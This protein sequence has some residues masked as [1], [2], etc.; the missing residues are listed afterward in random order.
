M[1]PAGPYLP[2]L[3][4]MSRPKHHGLEI[5]G[6]P[7][8]PVIRRT[9]MPFDGSKQLSSAQLS[10]TAADLIA[11]DAD[12]GAPSALVSTNPT[13]PLTE[14]RSV[15]SVIAIILLPAI[16]RPGDRPTD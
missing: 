5:W 10:V 15:V 14:G 7:V 9:L 6:I 13:P 1:I 3:G 11:A 8:R 16:N 12:G 2:D 4:V